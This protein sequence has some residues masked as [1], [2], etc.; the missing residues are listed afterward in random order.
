MI[1]VMKH[2]KSFLSLGSR[3]FSNNPTPLFLG[4]LGLLFLFIVYLAVTAFQA[5]SKKKAAQKVETRTSA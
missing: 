1:L 5:F 3:M 4:V 2:F